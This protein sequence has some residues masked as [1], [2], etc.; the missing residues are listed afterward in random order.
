M[1]VKAIFVKDTQ[2]ISCAMDINN[3]GQVVGN[4]TTG[5][6]T[7]KHAFLYKRLPNLVITDAEIT[8]CNIL[9]NFLFILLLSE[10]K[11]FK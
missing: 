2:F 5:N 6:S 3:K 1:G 11:Y 8:L 7:D 10:F 9:L 4:S